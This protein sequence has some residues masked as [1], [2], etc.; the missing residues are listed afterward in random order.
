MFFPLA[1]V[2]PMKNNGE[3]LQLN[4]RL[5]R[6]GKATVFKMLKQQNL[7]GVVQIKTLN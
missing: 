6:V 5:T 1:K 4:L 3:L 7:H 2:C